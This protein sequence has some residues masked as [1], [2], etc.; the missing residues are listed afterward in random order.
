MLLDFLQHLLN[1]TTC[2]QHI[3]DFTA[4][5][6]KH[7][8]YSSPHPF[9]TLFRH[10]IFS[11]IPFVAILPLLKTRSSFA[12]QPILV[13]TCEFDPIKSYHIVQGEKGS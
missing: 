10:K 12:S 13:V 4:K 3:I 2:P 1:I 6:W 11:E 9:S 5:T 8:K 7:C